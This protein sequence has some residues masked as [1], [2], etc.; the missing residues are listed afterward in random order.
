[1]HIRMIFL[2]K[3]S[4]CFFESLVVGIF[5]DAENLV[6]ISLGICHKLLYFPVF[7]VNHIVIGVV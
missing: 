1:M 3:S 7:S 6:I 2:G 4:V 5:V